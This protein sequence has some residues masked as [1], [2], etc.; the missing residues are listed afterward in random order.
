MMT[1]T[2]ASLDQILQELRN[3]MD[4]INVRLDPLPALVQDVKDLK[5]NLRSIENSI[6]GIKREVNDSINRIASVEQRVEKLEVIP[7]FGAGNPLLESKVA[8]IFSELSSKEQRDRINNVEI[9][10]VPLKKNENLFDLVSKVGAS[11]GQPVSK[12]D[13]NFVTRARSS[14]DQKPIIVGFIGRYLKENFVASAKSKK[15][16]TAEDIGFVGDLTKI[17]INDHLTRENKQ[18]LS[19][20]KKFAQEKNYSFV[21]VQNCKILTRKNATSPFIVI[22]NDDE[23]AK[24]K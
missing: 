9:K 5:S 17:F 3:G 15:K 23:L 13:I 12:T 21:W 10:G 1:P 7:H 20:T 2:A 8:M 11:I 24:I 4:G 14:S 18:L 19:R 22:H 16:M 6:S